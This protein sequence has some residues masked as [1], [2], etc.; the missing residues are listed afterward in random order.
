MIW[1]HYV[2]GLI[3]YVQ[4]IS[5]IS[6]FFSFKFPYFYQI[7]VM[8]FNLFKFLYWSSFELGANYVIMPRNLLV[9]SWVI[10]N[11]IVTDELNAEAKYCANCKNFEDVVFLRLS[12]SL[13]LVLWQYLNHEVQLP[14][15]R[16]VRNLETGPHGN[17]P[18][19]S[20]FVVS[21]KE[22]EHCPV[23]DR[24][25]WAVCPVSSMVNRYR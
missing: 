24:C 9:T 7:A 11:F 22:S 19:T 23:V 18:R 8:D 25:P 5:Y 21:L 15:R 10:V 12:S 17:W 3:R 1:F 6:E 16:A 13:S 4:Y 2:T 14:K 20:R